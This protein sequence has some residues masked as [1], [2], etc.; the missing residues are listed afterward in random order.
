MIDVVIELTKERLR[1]WGTHLVVRFGF[2]VRLS[3][4][5]T[6]NCKEEEKGGVKIDSGRIN[7]IPS[8]VS[9]IDTYL[10]VVNIV[11]SSLYDDA[12]STSEA[13]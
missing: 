7:S 10:R 9:E 11:V 4:C 6:A 13:L 5:N 8:E 12:T 1:N 3:A 2:V